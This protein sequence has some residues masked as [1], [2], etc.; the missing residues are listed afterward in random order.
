MVNIDDDE[1]DRSGGVADAVDS[2]DDDGEEEGWTTAGSVDEG[3]NEGD[4]ASDGVSV[5]EDESTTGDGFN[6][7][8]RSPSSVHSNSES[9][10]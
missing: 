5:D 8:S 4:D 6:A 10:S 2:D 7:A 3:V 9:A 1:S